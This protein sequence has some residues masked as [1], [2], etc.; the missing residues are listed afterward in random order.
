MRIVLLA[1][2][3]LL[4]G[5]TA[6]YAAEKPISVTLVSGTSTGTVSGKAG[7]RWHIAATTRPRGLRVLVRVAGRPDRIGKSPIRFEYSC[8]G[9]R[10]RAAAKLLPTGGK[11]VPPTATLTVSLYR[12]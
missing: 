8:A 7:N 6:A 5:L 1:S 4:F 10:A 12:G 11:P 9:C 3:V 2:A